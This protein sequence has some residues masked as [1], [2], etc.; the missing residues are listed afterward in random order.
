M[1]LSVHLSLTY[2]LAR[3]QQL[4]RALPD[5]ILEEDC[6]P[7]PIAK[8]CTPPP[9]AKSP[10]NKGAPVAGKDPSSEKAA[11]Q[12]LA[13]PV[14]SLK[15]TDP[16][17]STPAPSVLPSHPST[18]SPRPSTASSMHPPPSPPLPAP[19][20]DITVNPQPNG[21]LRHSQNDN[22]ATPQVTDGAPSVPVDPRPNSALPRP[23][24]G[25]DAAPPVTDSVP[26]AP[27]DPQHQGGPPHPQSNN[28]IPPLV[29][30]DTTRSPSGPPLPG[31]SSGSSAEIPADHD[32]PALHR[33]MP[34]PQ[35][36]LTQG[37]AQTTPIALVELDQSCID[38]LPQS[39]HNDY[40]AILSQEG[41][42]VVWT[43]IVVLFSTFEL[44]HVR[45]L[46]SH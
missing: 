46:F 9:I 33:R 12:P 34:S 29:T 27:T 38:N 44:K 22:D 14:Q 17:S 3:E 16:S 26:N 31:D 39:A 2:L 35:P 42:G 4:A 32:S 30:D 43:N 25:T 11:Q 20:L 45:P 7:P 24:D 8:S 28:V 41:W 5:T 21:V 36:P 23:Q 13:P 19:G 15:P 1:S 37:L 6:T 10:P 40:K 18:P